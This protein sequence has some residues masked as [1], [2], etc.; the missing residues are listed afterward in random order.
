MRSVS[1]RQT[2]CT[3]HQTTHAMRDGCPDG[4]TDSRT[5]IGAFVGT[6]TVAF[7]ANV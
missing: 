4:S 1:I 3:R 5:N 6:N 7:A 2:F